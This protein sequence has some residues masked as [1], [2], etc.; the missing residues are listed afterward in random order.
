VQRVA[1]AAVTVD[2]EVTG[3]IG[4][5]LLVLVGFT[6]SDS[7]SQVAWMADKLADLRIF[8][9]DD[10]KMNRDLRQAG[11]AILVVSQFTL[12]GDASQGRRPSFTGAA[13][14]AQAEPLYR[15]FLDQLRS[16]G[17]TVASGVFGAMMRVS[18]I[19]DGPVTL[20]I[21]R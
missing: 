20:V 10:G 19:N 7:D 16:R 2:G 18:L 13:P 21:E 15:Q 4:A 8:S 3:A 14:A 9:D 11:G 5:G 12:Y 1:Q 6:A 17:L